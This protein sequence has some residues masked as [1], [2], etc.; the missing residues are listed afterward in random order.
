MSAALFLKRRGWIAVVAALGLTALGVVSAAARSDVSHVAARPVVPLRAVIYETA[1]LKAKAG[2]PAAAAVGRSAA[3]V[4]FHLSALTWARADAAIVRWNGR[5]TASDRTLAALLKGIVSTRA[6]VRAAALIDRARGG[7]RAQ[8]RALARLR[9]ASRGYLHVRS[10]PA[11]F[12]ALADRSLRSCAQARRWRAAARGL[13]IAEAAFTGYSSCRSAA[14][15]WFRD[16]PV[17]RTARAS[18]SFL[19]RPGY[20]QNSKRT[21]KVKRSLAAWRRSIQRMV[22]SHQPLQ[23]I[24]SLNDWAHGSAIEPS[25]AWVSASGF[26][27]YLDALHGSTGV[28][29]PGDTPPQ[30]TTGQPGAPTVAATTVSDVTA[31]HATVSSTVSAGASPAT[32]WV[33]YGPTTAYGQTTTPVAVA[34]GS[35]HRV[36]VVLSVSPAVHYLAHVVVSSAVGRVSS[37]DVAFTTLASS[38]VMRIAAAGDI[39]CD[40]SDPN[41]NGGQ[42]TATA[43]QQFAVSS[44]ILAGHYDAVLPLGDEQYNAGSAQAFAAS[45]HPSWG[46]LDAI[47]HPVVGNHE[48]G[49]PGAGP[50]FQYFGASAGTPGQGWYSYDLG[51]WHVI[52]LNANCLRIAGGCGVGSPQELWLRADLA[53]HPVGCTLAYWHQPL[54]TSGQE[55]STTDVSTF[56]GD[57]SAAGAEIVLNG[58]EHGYERFSPQTPAGQRDD[59]HGIREFVVGTGGDNHMTFHATPAANTEVRDNTS[60]GFLELTLSNG[61]Y[62]WRFQPTAPGA[63]TDS[64]TGTCH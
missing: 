38:E 33:E 28:S 46:R 41:F 24:D 22:A 43:C 34:P 31:H 47:A 51:A 42:G 10:R 7:A 50:Y 40:P 57:L 26:G 62:A 63:F 2:R 6:H 9:V 37:P 16:A 35:A 4:R 13:W 30:T 56:W 36:S 32:L 48:Y 11:V 61:A 49:R 19:I 59:A 64:G 15:A 27:L 14:D 39:A 52:A 8:L 12:V 45:Y 17:A 3:A 58:H 21:P 54:F 55:P 60:F 23:V 44:A 1:P 29:P 53:A 25:P 18:G 5:G 20:W